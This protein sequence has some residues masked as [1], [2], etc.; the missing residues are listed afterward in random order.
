MLAIQKQKQQLERIVTP[1]TLQETLNLLDNYREKAR[2]IAGGTDILLE[3]HRQTRPGVEV[4]LDISRLPNLNRVWRD[5][6]G[7]VHLGPLVTHNQAVATPLLVQEALPLVQACWE[8]GSP[9]LRNRATIV[10]NLVTASPANDTITP[11]WAL[12]AHLTLATAVG[13][14]TVPLRDFYTGVR[15]TVLA[16]GE[17]VTD[18]HFVPLKAHQRGLYVKLG[19]RR[20]QAISV[21]HL[22][23]VVTFDPEDEAQIQEREITAVEIVL[24]SV[25]PTI[26]N[27]TQ[28]E[29]YLVGRTLTD[30]TIAETARLT[31]TEPSPI[32]DIRSTAEYRTHMIEVMVRRALETLRAGQERAGWPTDPIMLATPHN[33]SHPPA[34]TT[35]YPAGKQ[36]HA[37]L[38]TRIN[39]VPVTA[40]VSPNQTLLDWLRDTA[41]LTGTKEGCAE[42]ECGAC[43]CFLDGQA[44]MS[45]LVPATRAHGADIVTIEGL[46]DEDTG[47]LHPLQEAFIQAGA[48]QCGYCIP[49]FLMSGAKLLAEQENPTRAQIEQAFSGN[50]CRCTGYYKII[51]AVEQAA[52]HRQTSTSLAQQSEG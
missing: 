42:G 43:T 40:E 50:L 16:P 19:L 20:A 38:S 24:G 14:R 5:D 51:T 41:E 17:M 18:I 8:V 29:N 31:A 39:G 48:V 37:Q 26:V 28:A 52:A 3:L 35:H 47:Q 25:A 45:C 44:V 23:V 30:E 4:L 12:D 6:H 7:R 2:L 1:A 21:V 9:Q 36:K 32:D 13:E 10:G 27:A 22:T 34:Q 15:R 49:G 33:L 46:A 11:L